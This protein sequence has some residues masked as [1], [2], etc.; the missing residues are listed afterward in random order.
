MKHL[1]PLLV[2]ALGTGSSACVLDLTNLSGGGGSGTTTTSTTTGTTGT[3]GT[4]S[5]TGTGTTSTT[6]TS[7]AP[8]TAAQLLGLTTSCNRYPGSTDFMAIAGAPNNVPICTLNGA[9]WW[10]SAMT[11][12]CDGGSGSVCKNAPGYSSQTAGTDSMGNPLD[13]STLPF[14]VVPQPSDGFDY[15]AAGISFGSVSAV[16]YKGKLEYAVV[17]DTGD[18]G[19]V[20]EGSFALAQALNIDPNPSTGGVTSGVTYITFTGPTSTV[21][22]SEDHSEADALGAMLAAQLVANN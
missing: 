11:I 8:V 3:S 22:K 14:V 13:A 7:S 19:I 10:T 1:A 17:G 4:T 2:A 15:D 21:S 18:K 5:T 6:S 20:G 9:V 16:I 12:A